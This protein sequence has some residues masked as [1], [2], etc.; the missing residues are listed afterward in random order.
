MAARQLRTVGCEARI[1]FD[2]GRACRTGRAGGPAAAVYSIVQNEPNFR[3]FCGRNEGRREEQTQ[4][5][6][7]LTAVAARNRQIRNAKFEIRD[8]YEIRITQTPIPGFGP[9]VSAPFRVSIFALRVSR[10]M[11]AICQTKPIIAVSG[12]ET[13]GSGRNKANFSRLETRGPRLEGSDANAIR[14]TR[15]ER[16]VTGGGSAPNKANFACFG[17]KMGVGLKNKANQSQLGRFG[18]D[19]G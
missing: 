11:R 5:R 12:P 6:R 3:R 10:R 13:G 16:R 8:K 19:R 7:F 2:C 9:T 15:Y 18:R 1:L 14:C 17:L 4:F